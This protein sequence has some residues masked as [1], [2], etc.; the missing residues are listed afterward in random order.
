MI[1]RLLVVGTWEKSADT[2]N[3][4][5]LCLA[6][7]YLRSFRVTRRADRGLDRFSLMGARLVLE[8]L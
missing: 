8:V 3:V 4:R 6:N 1:P 5:G 7:W 2:R